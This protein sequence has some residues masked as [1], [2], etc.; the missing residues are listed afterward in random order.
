MQLP[1]G[2]QICQYQGGGRARRPM[3]RDIFQIIVC[4]CLLYS[5]SSPVLLT[6][7]S[8]VHNGIAS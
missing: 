3:H 2:E 4:L 6:K 7:Y 1:S 8:I 5:A